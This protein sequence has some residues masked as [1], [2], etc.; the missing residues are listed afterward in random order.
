MDTDLH[1]VCSADETQINALI[2]DIGLKCVP[3]SYPNSE[4]VS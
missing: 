1:K 3:A 2:Y 4:F